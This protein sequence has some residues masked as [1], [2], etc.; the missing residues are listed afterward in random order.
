[1]DGAVKLYRCERCRK[2]Q[3][4]FTVAGTLERGRW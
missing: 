1:M 3:A 4:G 2:W